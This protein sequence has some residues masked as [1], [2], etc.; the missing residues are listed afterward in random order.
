MAV[1]FGGDL[2]IAKRRLIEAS[3]KDHIRVM[4]PK[5]GVGLWVDSWTIPADAANVLNAHR[6][7]NDQLDPHVAAKNGDYV[8]YA[9]A[10]LP[11]RDLMAAEYSQD[12]SIFP[13]DEE[14][15]HSF[16]MV[17]LEPEA[18]RNMVRQWQSVKAGK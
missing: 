18:L 8:S 3:G 5:E 6:Y 9:P 10:S 17:P 14:L 15:E 1:G 2:N 11:A 13:T 12:H 7:I 4:M 16:V